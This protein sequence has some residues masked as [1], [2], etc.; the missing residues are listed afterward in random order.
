MQKIVIVFL[1]IYEFNKFEKS[2]SRGLFRL[3]QADGTEIKF[4]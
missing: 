1:Y 2:I 4:T 3:M